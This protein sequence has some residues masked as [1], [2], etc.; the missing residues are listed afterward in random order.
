MVK[1]QMAES[2]LNLGSASSS[3]SSGEVS[4]SLE[5]DTVDENGDGNGCGAVAVAE[6]DSGKVAG[7][8]VSNGVSDSS[9][10]VFLSNGNCVV[11]RD[12]V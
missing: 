7:G 4:V 10:F 6:L 9:G 5:K 2:S 1:P 11:Y 3:S 12:A 8:S